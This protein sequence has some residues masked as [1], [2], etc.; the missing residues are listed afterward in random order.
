MAATPPTNCRWSGLATLNIRIYDTW[1]HMHTNNVTFL[2]PKVNCNN[3]AFK[4]SSEWSNF[5]RNIHPKNDIQGPVIFFFLCFII[6]VI[7]VKFYVRSQ[8]W[9][10][11]Y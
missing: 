10:D 8:V 7:Q 4:K 2:W 6:A 9:I 3:L 11:S 5:I 1:T